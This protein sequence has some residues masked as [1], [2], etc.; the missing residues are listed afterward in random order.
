MKRKQKRCLRQRYETGMI[1]QLF[2]VIMISKC[3]LGIIE[4]N[5]ISAKTKLKICQV[6]TS[7]IQRQ[8]MSR[9]AQL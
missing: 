8:N 7:S 5:G 1:C 6:L 4:L 9:R 3:V 2:T